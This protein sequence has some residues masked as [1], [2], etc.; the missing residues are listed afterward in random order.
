MKKLILVLVV[1][2]AAPALADLADEVRCREI[3]FSK[4]IESRDMEAFRSFLDDDARFI[5]AQVKRGPEE[6]TDAW[7][8]YEPEDGP[9]LKWRPQFVEVLEDGKLALSRGPWRYTTTDEEG[10]SV[11]LWGMF[12]SV[13]RLQDDGSWK[14][15]FDAGGPSP[16]GPTDEQR[17]LIDNDDDVTL[18]GCGS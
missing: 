6:V 1:I 14:V 13:W 8:T 12:N 5:G 3:G 2:G 9:T 15:V 7:R 4:S 10:E 17:A 18:L 16:S 11:E